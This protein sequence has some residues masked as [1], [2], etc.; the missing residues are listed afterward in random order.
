M[1]HACSAPLASR[2]R[3]TRCRRHRALAVGHSQAPGQ[4]GA[5]KLGVRRHS[6]P[7]FSL[8]QYGNFDNKT[9]KVAVPLYAAAMPKALVR[10]T[11]SRFVRSTESSDTAI[12]GVYFN[13]SSFHTRPCLRCPMRRLLIHRHIQQDLGAVPGYRADMQAAGYESRGTAF[14]AVFGTTPPAAQRMPCT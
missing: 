12:R 4:P 1:T 13:K 7:A 6:P 9:M 14:C 5:A 2:R 3:T 11:S 8:I 10:Q